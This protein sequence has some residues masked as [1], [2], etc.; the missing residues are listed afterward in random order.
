MDT[1]T[2]IIILITANANEAPKISR[3]LID[4]KKAACVNTVSGIK[5]LFWWE[6]KIDLAQ[7]NML[8]VKTKLELLNEIIELVKTIHSD[9]VP[10]I[11]ALPII[12]GNKGYLEWINKVLK[13]Q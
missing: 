4:Q 9:K 13:E 2:F 5:S 8:I 10:E 12:S 3:A 6:G 1:N 7:E 11:I